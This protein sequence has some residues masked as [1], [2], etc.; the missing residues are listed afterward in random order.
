VSLRHVATKA[1]QGGLV[2]SEYEV[3]AA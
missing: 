3:I 2:Q 1:F